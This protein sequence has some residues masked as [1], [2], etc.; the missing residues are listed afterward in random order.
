[1]GKEL[2]TIHG[3]KRNVVIWVHMPPSDAHI[4]AHSRRESYGSDQ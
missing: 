3:N 2:W 1:M 4:Q